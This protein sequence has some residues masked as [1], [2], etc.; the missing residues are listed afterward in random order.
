MYVLGMNVYKAGV[1]VCDK[2]NAA[3]AFLKNRKIQNSTNDTLIVTAAGWW[4][5]STQPFRQDS[6]DLLVGLRLHLRVRV[7]G[8]PGKSMAKASPV[9]EPS[10]L[11]E[12]TTITL[13]HVFSSIYIPVTQHFSDPVIYMC[14]TL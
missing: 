14:D 9:A 7:R 5:S 12:L 1:K 3:K 10:T 11:L 2:R 6:R 8:Q 4:A 13:M